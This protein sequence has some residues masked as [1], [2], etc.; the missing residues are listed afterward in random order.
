MLALELLGRQRRLVALLVVLI[1][2]TGVHV[3]IVRRETREFFVFETLLLGR[4]ALLALGGVLA[5]LVTDLLV[6]H[7][8]DGHDVTVLVNNDCRRVLDVFKELVAREPAR[9]TAADGRTGCL[10][11]TT[12]GFSSTSDSSELYSR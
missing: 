3:F 5:L 8:H 1:V 7:G 9:E 11:E 10:S 12:S 4:A 6:R 2:R